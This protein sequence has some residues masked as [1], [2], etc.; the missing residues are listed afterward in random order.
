MVKLNKL[1]Q[2]KLP[3]MLFLILAL[4]N[5]LVAFWQHLYFS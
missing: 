5:H 4:P 3:F 2:G 1:S